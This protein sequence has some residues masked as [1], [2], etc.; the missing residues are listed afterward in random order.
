MQIRS[1]NSS[2]SQF[3]RS[4]IFIVIS[5]VINT[6]ANHKFHIGIYKYRHPLNA[7]LMSVIFRQLICYNVTDIGL[8]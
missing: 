5:W 8:F 6:S 3:Q 2:E 4:D 1:Q 7:V